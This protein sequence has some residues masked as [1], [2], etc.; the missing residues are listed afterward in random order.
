[1]LEPD[2]SR[3]DPGLSAAARWAPLARFI[4]VEHALG[5]AARARGPVWSAAYEFVRFGLKQ[6]WACLFGAA[7]LVLIIGTRF[8]YPH[9]AIIPRY[10]VIFI[11]AVAIQII[12]LKTRLETLD[13]AKVIF[14]FHVIGTIMEVHKTSIGSWIYPEPSI[15][16]IRG[17]PLFTGFMYASVGSYLARVW[18]LFDFRFT[19]H[20]SLRA[21]AA[22][23]VAIYANFLLD[24]RGLDGRYALIAI[25]AIL[26]ARTTIHFKIW[27]R[28]RFMPLLLGFV[29]VASFI[30]LAEN[31][32]TYTGTW[33]YPRQ[34]AH[35]A[36]VPISKLTSWFLLMIISYTMVAWINGI[37]VLPA[38]DEITGS[39]ATTG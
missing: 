15:F 7:M 1:M 30:W 25:T 32:G 31:L 39:E 5:V 19:S 22:L 35:W 12:M 16:H 23:S 4:R 38:E 6:A 18:R 37:A 13:E 14:A 27:Q 8:L 21:T 24:D 33:L 11:G 20:P 26:Y 9:H 10:D 17:V 36:M 28:H 2:V 34:V 3:S 29:L